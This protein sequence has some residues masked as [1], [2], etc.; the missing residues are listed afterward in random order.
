MDGKVRARSDAV[1]ARHPVGDANRRDI[2]N[3]IQKIVGAGKSYERLTAARMGLAISDIARLARAAQSKDKK[4]LHETPSC[5]EALRISHYSI[6]NSL[7]Q[8]S[9]LQSRS[10]GDR[11]RSTVNRLASSIAPLRLSRC[12]KR[13]KSRPLTKKQ[14]FK[15][16]DRGIKRPHPAKLKD[17]KCLERT[18]K[19]RKMQDEAKVA[20]Q[21]QLAM[22]LDVLHGLRTS[23][24]LLP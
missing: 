16:V 22:L 4:L 2:I 17:S 15:L 20:G 1:L 5:V 13:G 19:L 11:R 14:I 23:R 3:R 18:Q 9:E 8:Y 24:C 7:K 6:E 10:S 12:F 21:P